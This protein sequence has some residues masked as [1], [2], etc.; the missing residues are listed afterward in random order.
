[1]P[2]YPWFHALAVPDPGT[3]GRCPRKILAN[4]AYCFMWKFSCDVVA[5]LH[6]SPARE[7]GSSET[8]TDSMVGIW[9]PTLVVVTMVTI[10]KLSPLVS[11]S[12]LRVNKEQSNTKHISNTMHACQMCDCTNKVHLS[13]WSWYWPGLCCLKVARQSHSGK[14]NKNINQGYN[15][16]QGYSKCQV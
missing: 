13:S 16:D 6:V 11:S 12:L 8:T 4:C 7:P 14:V 10:G 15:Q 2:K 1:M 9:C 5:P 3:P